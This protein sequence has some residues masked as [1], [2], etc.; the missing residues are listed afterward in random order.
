MKSLWSHG[1]S[2][3]P[4]QICVIVEQY[5]TMEL[6][7]MRIDIKPPGNL[8]LSKPKTLDTPS[9]PLPKSTVMKVCCQKSSC[10]YRKIIW[11]CLDIQTLQILE[12]QS[13]VLSS[14]EVLAHLTE[15]RTKPRTTP[16]THSN[17]STVLKE[18]L[19]PFS[20]LRSVSLT[21]TDQHLP[22]PTDRL[23]LSDSPVP[24]PQL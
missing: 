1:T 16:Q 23:P 19:A 22:Q 21:P 7:L 9:N 10:R 12:S 24:A 15:S 5:H 14:Y 4:S 18:V 3:K 2:R 6:R 13:A 8:P 11:T 20:H 17:V